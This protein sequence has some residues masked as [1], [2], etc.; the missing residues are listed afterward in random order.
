MAI[1]PYTAS[2]LPELARQVEVHPPILH[3]DAAAEVAM[4]GRIR[5]ID[6]PP[7]VP[8]L[9]RVDGAVVG[10]VAEL[11]FIPDQVLPE[12]PLPDAALAFGNASGSMARSSGLPW[13]T[14]S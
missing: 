4:E 6:R 2:P 12:P 14:V 9:H 1:P 10:I 11:V 3:V 7:H 8:M 13:R 5:P